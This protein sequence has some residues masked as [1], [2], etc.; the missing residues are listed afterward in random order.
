MNSK[1]VLYR[2]EDDE[3]AERE[4]SI[5]L[6][7]AFEPSIEN[8]RRIVTQ[9][10]YL[11]FQWEGRNTQ[12]LVDVQSATLIVRIYDAANEKNKATM[13]RMIK[14]SKWSFISLINQLQ[15]LV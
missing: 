4:G 5:L 8:V 1:Q 9:H 6:D 15:A 13:E 10:Q 2:T 3:L 11:T 14:K 12:L 7:D